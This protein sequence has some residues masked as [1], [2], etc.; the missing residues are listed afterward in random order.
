MHSS[1]RS[2]TRVCHSHRVLP[3]IECALVASAGTV[4]LPVGVRHASERGIR[5]D[6]H[7]QH[8]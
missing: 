7:R 1:G 6:T 8:A 2:L 3:C 4:G 5:R